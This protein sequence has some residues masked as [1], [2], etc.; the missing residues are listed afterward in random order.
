MRQRNE[1]SRRSSPI[2]DLALPYLPAYL[3][4]LPQRLGPGLERRAPS[5][6]SPSFGGGAP[7]LSGKVN[8]I[9]AASAWKTHIARHMTS[10][11]SLFPTPFA[12]ADPLLHPY[13]AGDEAAAEERLETLVR[14][15][16]L[17]I[18]RGVVG[19]RLGRDGCDLDDICNDI[20][21]QVVRR[22]R[23]ARELGDR[24]PIASFRGY[25]ATAAYR[26]CDAWL[27]EKYPERHRLRN[28]VQYLV[29]HHP[30]FF[31]RGGEETAVAVRPGTRYRFARPHGAAA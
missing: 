2:A 1:A 15:E 17:P 27:R 20:V 29:S 3:P 18:V 26:G 12:A 16:A 24:Q 21:L 23:A 14:D 10:V 8:W 13:F 7:L 19:V 22:L 6:A 25:V 31:L 4:L 28:R 5:G 11:P 30:G 9:T